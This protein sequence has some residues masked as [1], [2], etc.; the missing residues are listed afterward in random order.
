MK[1]SLQ[2]SNKERGELCIFHLIGFFADVF[3]MS[4][5]LSLLSTKSQLSPNFLPNAAVIWGQ[6]CPEFDGFTMLLLIWLKI[7][8]LEHLLV[9]H[10]K[11]QEDAKL[12]SFWVLFPLKHDCSVWL[13]VEEWSKGKKVKID[14]KRWTDLC[15]SDLATKDFIC[16]SKNLYNLE[17]KKDPEE[18]HIAKV[19]KSILSQLL[20]LLLSGIIFCYNYFPTLNSI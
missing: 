1:S 17:M 2:L 4:F 9:S 15:L 14:M 10:K 12:G 5:H 7:Q 16:L 3:S 11:E 18:E 20:L 6:L 19:C 13:C 8:F